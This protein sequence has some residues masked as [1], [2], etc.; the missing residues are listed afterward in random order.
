LEAGSQVLEGKTVIY[1]ENVTP[2]GLAT[3][4]AE[5][6]ADP[7][8]IRAHVRSHF[9]RAPSVDVIRG[10]RRKVEQRRQRQ[11]A[12]AE[13][14]F[15]VHCQRH[16]GPYE[17]DIDGYDRCTQ[18]RDEKRAAEQ[19][20]ADQSAKMARQLAAMQARVARQKQLAEEAR[21]NELAVVGHILENHGKP[22]LFQDLLVAVAAAF[23]MTPA[24]ITGTN[25]E[26]VYVDARTAI[27]RIL[28]IRGSSYPM[29]GKRLNR[30]HSSI[31]HLER[32][33]D[34]R[35]KRN[36]LIALVVDR[37]A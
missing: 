36:P 8:T 11:T 21:R 3:R 7:S 23:E 16:S 19:A 27:T 14:K 32:G 12:Y 29:I 31:V 30:D 10:I 15:I 17:L 33:Y 24:D 34:F 9:G 2:T 4:L 5:Y 1:T 22:V 18:C 37:L 35:A 28:R 13:D 6:I 25:R 26:R 20:K